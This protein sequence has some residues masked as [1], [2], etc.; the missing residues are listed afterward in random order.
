[1][2]N[3]DY[4]NTLREIV[5]LFYQPPFKIFNVNSVDGETLVRPF[6]YFISLGITT[7]LDVLKNLRDLIS[8]SDY[9]F[10][11]RLVELESIKS[12]DY[13]DFINVLS[14]LQEDEIKKYPGSSC[15]E[16]M[17]IL[18]KEE[19]EKMLDELTT[20]INAGD[21]SLSVYRQ[22]LSD[23]LKK[24][25]NWDDYGVQIKDGQL[26]IFHKF[27]NYRKTDKSEFRIGIYVTKI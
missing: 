23:I 26:G 5:E 16:D 17:K 18:G 22:R 12:D 13:G 19:A 9:G 3:V 10:E 11:A 1:M 2:M 27:I 24:I 14:D 4:R 20:K 8:K 25:E 15:P 6:G 7:S 21:Y